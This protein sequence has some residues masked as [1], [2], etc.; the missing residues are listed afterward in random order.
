MELL[1]SRDK[2]KLLIAL[3]LQFLV[4]LLD[5]LGVA[6]F[7]VI[8]SI[9]ISGVSGKQRGLRVSQVLE[10]IGLENLKLYSERKI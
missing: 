10:K 8:G 7:G 5:L 6:I 9:A 2:Q 3:F 1:T 4:N